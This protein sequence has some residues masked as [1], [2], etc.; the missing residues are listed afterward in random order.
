SGSPRLATSPV[1]GEGE[2]SSPC[3]PRTGSATPAVAQS[4]AGGGMLGPLPLPVRERVCAIRRRERAPRPRT[5][6]TP[7][8]NANRSRDRDLAGSPLYALLAAS[9]RGLGGARG[10]ADPAQLAH[11]AV[12]HLALHD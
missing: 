5:R 9:A 6:R 7:D 11:P 12:P 3:A 8:S 2:F 4:R 10:E 1:P